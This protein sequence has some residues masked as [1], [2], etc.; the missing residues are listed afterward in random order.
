MG[1]DW[2][3]H[4]VF[5]SYSD[6]DKAIADAICASLEARRIRCWMRSRD[7]LPGIPEV[8]S[9]LDGIHNSR[10]M[11][12]I[13]STRSDASTHVMREVQKATES[14]IPIIPFRI[15]DFQMNP[16]MEYYLGSVHW[17]DA[18]TPPLEQHLDK[19][20]IT[21]QRLLGIPETWPESPAPAAG[22]VPAP[23]FEPAP[24]PVR[25][26]T[27]RR[28]SGTVVVVGLVAAILL[29]S[30]IAV[31]LLNGGNTTV[32]GA[33]TAVPTRQPSGGI[34]TAPI[35]ISNLQPIS[36]VADNG[37]SA[38]FRSDVARTGVYTSQAAEKIDG[39]LWSFK[40][41]DVISG[42]PAIVGDMVYDGSR[43][44]NIYAIDRSTGAEK[45]RFHTGGGIET[46]PTVEDGVVYCGSDDGYLYSLDAATGKLKWKYNLKGWVRSVPAVWGNNVYL[47]S[48]DSIVYALDKTTGKVAG[49]FDLCRNSLDSYQWSSP[50]IADN[51]LYVTACD[52]P[53]VYAIDLLAGKLLWYF[54]TGDNQIV[55]ATPAIYDGVVYVGNTNGDFFALD[56]DT[57]KKIWSVKAGERIFSS[58]AVTDGMVYVGTYS[59]TNMSGS[60]V[61]LE[62]KT[63]RTLW[64]NPTYLEV[65]S[66]PA[67]AGDIVYFGCYDYFLYALDAK[68]GEWR[69]AYRTGDRVWCS[70]AVY[71][72]VVY[73]GS[74]DSRLYAVD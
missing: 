39:A 66:S 32:P 4:D 62:R 73:F 27:R 44:G 34:P 47:I 2:M 58:A 51:I 22:K 41:D 65:M 25:K 71:D 56:A 5:I 46:S 10:A 33:P 12:V 26:V 30:V 29:L 31:V 42:T 8:K 21:L 60:L 13:I 19:L 72:G 3:V 17:L 74:T 37:A 45:W 52:K 63:G 53:Y 16:D 35:V 70:P 9:I 14:G 55:E 68:T 28:V 36:P 64:V 11:V 38:M 57:G 48:N 20:T 24:G 18:L 61:A 69:G 43:D 54:D 59:P 1:C 50:A 7:V 15:E 6:E 49:T 40:A 67:V 23:T